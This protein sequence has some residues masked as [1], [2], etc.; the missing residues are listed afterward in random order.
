[1]SRH[2]GAAQES[3]VPNWDA[4]RQRRV[5]E[6][7]LRVRTRRSRVWGVLALGS[8]AA[9]AVVLVRL[10]PLG[11]GNF[12]STPAGAPLPPPGVAEPSTANP[13]PSFTD[14]GDLQGQR[15]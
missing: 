11:I 5:L 7:A 14:G 9:T 3:M 8:A 13:A 12:N 6:R 10:V 15:G 2:I 1:M 4:T